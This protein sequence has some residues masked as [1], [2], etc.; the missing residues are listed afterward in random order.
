MGGLV[1]EEECVFPEAEW[2]QGRAR[3][4][5]SLAASSSAAETGPIPGRGRAEVKGLGDWGAVEWG[6]RSQ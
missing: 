1:E 6:R 3:G 5:R 4:H 2:V